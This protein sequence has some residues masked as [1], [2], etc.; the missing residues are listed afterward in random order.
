MF[1]VDIRGHLSGL[2]KTCAGV[3]RGSVLDPVRYTTYTS[4][5]PSPAARGAFLAT[6]A[7]DTVF[8]NDFKCWASRWNI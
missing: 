7:D 8:L 4:D 6:Y 5:L 1:A 3:P 2:R